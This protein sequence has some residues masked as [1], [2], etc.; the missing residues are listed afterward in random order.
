MLGTSVF[1]V[2]PSV[3]QVAGFIGISHQNVK[4]LLLRLQSKGL[5]G[6]QKDPDNQPAPWC[7]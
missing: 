1:E 3:S 4:Q 2:V 5:I 7:T 6:L